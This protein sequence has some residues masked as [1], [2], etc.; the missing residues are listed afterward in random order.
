MRPP[1]AP[2]FTPLLF[3]LGAC[4]AGE[5]LPSD[6]EAE[7][8]TFALSTEGA[9]TPAAPEC[10]PS[11]ITTPSST[12]AVC[13]GPWEYERWAFCSMSHSSC[14]ARI[15][16]DGRDGEPQYATCAREEFGTVTVTETVP[17][18]RRTVAARCHF[19]GELDRWICEMDQTAANSACRA[20]VGGTY[21]VRVVRQPTR[22]N[23]TAEVECSGTRQVTRPRSR[24]DAACGCAVD[25]EYPVCRVQHEDCGPDGTRRWS[26]TGLSRAAV[27]L[28]DR[29]GA[30]SATG[31]H[32][33]FCTS[34]DTLPMGTVTEVRAKYDRLR[35]SWDTRTA[36]RATYARNLRQLYE[37]R[38][39]A[40]T[41]EQRAFVRTLYRDHAGAP[42]ACG[43]APPTIVPSRCTDTTSADVRGALFRCSRLAMGHVPAVVDALEL[44]SCADALERASTMPADCG[45]SSARTSLRQSTT[46]IAARALSL[47]EHPT[48]GLGNFDR[49]LYLLD[50]WDTAMRASYAA[51]GPTDALRVEQRGIRSEMLGRFWRHGMARRDV[52][53]ALTA[54]GALES[55][56]V[57][58][59]D[60]AFALDREVLVAAHTR[61]ASLPA[62]VIGGVTVAPAITL[63]R[64]PMRGPVLLMITA[65]ALTGLDERLSDLAAL[66]D[67]ACQFARCDTRESPTRLARFF[68]VIAAL[69]HEPTL[70]AELEALPSAEA[71]DG[72]RTA[73]AAMRGQHAAFATAMRDAGLALPLADV[74]ATSDVA[75]EAAAIA[76]IVLLAERRSAAFAAIG[77]LDPIDRRTLYAGVNDRQRE[78]V[79][80]SMRS[81]MGRLEQNTRE[82]REDL[83]DIVGGLVDQVGNEDALAQIDVR[84]A[85]IARDIDLATQDIAGLHASASEE[86]VRFG[87]LGAALTGISSALDEGQFVQVGDVTRLALDGTAARWTSGRVDLGAH[88]VAT[89]QPEQGELVVLAPSGVWSPTCA[90]RALEVQGPGGGSQRL[91]VEGITIGPEGFSLVVSDGET[92][93]RSASEQS[94]STETFSVG[95][96]ASVCAGGSYMYG[97][98][99]VCATTGKSWAWGSETAEGHSGEHSTSW[100]S[101]FAS[102]LRLEGT[103]FPELPAGSLL[104]V[105]TARGDGVIRDVHVVRAPY[106]QILVS[107]AADLYVIANDVDCGNREDTTHALSVDVR[108]F[109]SETALASAVITQ[110]GETL[111]AVRALEPQLV[112]QGSILPSQMGALRSEAL[113]DLQTR[114]G[115][116][117]ATLPAPLA[118]L[119]E[120][121]LDREIVRLERAVQ[122]AAL[123]RQIDALALELEALRQERLLV[124]HHGR[125][126]QLVPTWT[127]RNLGG[128]RLRDSARDLASQSRRYLYPVL[129]LWYPEVLDELDIAE[130]AEP[131]LSAGP[132]SSTLD[133]V[134]DVRAVL[135]ATLSRLE[136]ATPGY[137]ET[138][139]RPIIAVSF[140]RPD[141]VAD[142]FTP[143]SSLPKADEQRS[144]TLWSDVQSL[145]TGTITIRPEDLYTRFGGAGG[146]LACTE[147]VPVVQRM[148]LF[149]VRPGGVTDTEDLND[150]RRFLTGRASVTQPFA[151]TSGPVTY[152]LGNAIWQQFQ[153]PVL[154][155]SY[156]G[157]LSTFV[158]RAITS[159]AA[160][161]PEGAVGLSP[162]GSMEID[163]QGLQQLR[164]G[165]LGDGITTP[166]TEATEIVLVMQIDSRST[167][168]PLSWVP[169]CAP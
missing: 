12:S 153:I 15:C 92:Q 144:A 126:T 62:V 99:T 82:Y 64:A 106:T 108:R 49:Q 137:K 169:Q 163:F 67:F 96:Q 18:A 16:P 53:D 27:I 24:K 161:L 151:E 90:L 75:P 118:G 25:L 107:S 61:V 21:R 160:E 44:A 29:N 166:G 125:L 138:A 60:R 109:Q 150:E 129:D 45:A 140:V 111:T 42:L 155:G 57:T 156:T 54:G 132:S 143:I 19:E 6:L 68:S 135:D 34:A 158:Q 157:A 30:W 22:A 31:S 112:A 9:D 122:I 123:D 98:A 110:M 103:P 33:S 38:G 102:G 36:A 81:A 117:Y 70:G 76:R 168:A 101:Q 79:L 73:F 141:V 5:A 13:R 52:L 147:A 51:D 148:A 48:A 134:S 115:R 80:T 154:Y 86:D 14:G 59:S 164:S 69:D 116:S 72:W 8:A 32:G 162:F 127:L 35:T 2:L 146:L 83:A 39:E 95:V 37:L 94:T 133:L 124:E 47:V 66:H 87:E 88:S 136:A 74:D 91:D 84:V 152:T 3:V 46:T 139:Q 28:S 4:A 97:S 1:F 105:E 10:G 56:L 113:V 11:S 89:I 145:S 121:F 77:L 142:P 40:L 149:V 20:Y 78:T 65:D 41:E 58:V 159:G 7:S 165:A 55:A 17:P 63:N 167:A 85:R 23:P 104:V 128:E 50:R 26:A 131:L 130:A 43:A 100:S 71:L 93:A 119:F 114:A 120:A